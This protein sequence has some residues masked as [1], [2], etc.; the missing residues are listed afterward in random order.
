MVIFHGYVSLP[1]GTRIILRFLGCGRGCG[2]GL[3]SAKL[4]SPG[5]SRAEGSAEGSAAA[6]T[7]VC[8]GGGL[9][10]KR[11]LPLTSNKHMAAMA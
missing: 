9:D 11:W 1:E 7:G 6:T 4:R 5:A 8:F 3:R 2:D 10:E